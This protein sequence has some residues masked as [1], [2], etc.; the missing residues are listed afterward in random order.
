MDDLATKFH[1]GSKEIVST[2]RAAAVFIRDSFLAR[3]LKISK[4]TTI[5]ASKPNI[6]NK[7]REDLGRIG[8]P[9]QS[10][11][12]ARDLGMDSAAGSRR[13]T[14]VMKG[15]LH[16]IVRRMGKLRVLESLE[17]RAKKLFRTNIWPAASFGAAA[18][19]VAK[20]SIKKLRTQAGL[21]AQGRGG[22]CTT[23]AI[24]LH[25]PSGRT[26][27]SRSGAK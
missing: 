9:C 19:G 13:S 7:I 27:P 2:V 5:V 17:K 12:A 22:Q 4:K 24:A 1:G 11:L 8:I 3:K 23:T 10:A 16:K 20:A 26:R 14:K 15:R 6:A 25:F 21:A 18:M